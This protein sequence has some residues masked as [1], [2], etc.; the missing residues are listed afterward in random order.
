MNSVAPYDMSLTAVLQVTLLSGL[1]F[2]MVS[3]YIS[4]KF[5]ANFPGP[6]LARFTKLWYAKSIVQ[7]NAHKVFDDLIKKYGEISILETLSLTNS[8][9]GHFVRIAPDILVTDDADLFIKV[10]AVKSPYR[11]SPSY[12]AAAFDPRTHNTVSTLDEG[13]HATLRSKVGFAVCYVFLIIGD[14]IDTASILAKI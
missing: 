9:S 3:T 13:V 8:S 5:L 1:S 11:R 14:S 10:N 2:L 6:F 4:Y 12:N 7:E